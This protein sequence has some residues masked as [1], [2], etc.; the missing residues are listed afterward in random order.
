MEEEFISLA[1]FSLQLTRDM[2]VLYNTY[3]NI[4]VSLDK[5]AR[6][7]GVPTCEV[8][9]GGDSGVGSIP[10]WNHLQVHRVNERGNALYTGIL[11]MG[12]H[13]FT[14]TKHACAHG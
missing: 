10:V 7:W 11:H 6:I 1:Y 12:K 13:V 14:R 4:I 9:A 8:V 3:E 5:A 2:F